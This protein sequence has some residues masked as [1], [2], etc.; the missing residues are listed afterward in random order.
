MSAKSVKIK[1]LDIYKPYIN[2]NIKL[3]IKEKHRLQRLFNKKPLTYGNQY[4]AARNHLNAV[5]RTA[6]SKYF[7]SKINNTTNCGE[8]WKVV[9]KLLGRNSRRE[10]PDE[11]IIDNS[12]VSD[13]LKIANEFNR[14]FTG[15]GSSLAEK[16]MSCDEYKNYLI[17]NI[18]TV[19]FV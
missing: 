15:I 8:S 4:R 19:F 12:P 1:K 16:F 6:K 5:I 13:P 2:N 14:Y 7:Q 10:L 3:L 9:N 17:D 18:G 11:F